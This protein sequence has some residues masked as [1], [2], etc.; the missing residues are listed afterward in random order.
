MEKELMQQLAL[1]TG[2]EK[3]VVIDTNQLD[4]VH[5]FRMFCEQNACG[6]YGTN[7]GCPPYCGEPGEMEERARKYSH[8]LVLQS[9]TLVDNIFDDSETKVIK[10][11]HTR[12]TLELIDK[13]HEKGFKQEGLPIM[14]GPCNLCD[15][16]GMPKGKPCPHNQQRFSCLSAYCIDA[17][18]MAET[19][20]MEMIW[21]GDTVS[22]FS[23]YLFD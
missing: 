21:N 17:A 13:F 19:C 1:E 3:A 11:E 16:C 22:F 4:F 20:D 15:T 2:F 7:Y 12:K 23:L 5:E 18:K 10:K 14:A 6:N 8:A 9:K